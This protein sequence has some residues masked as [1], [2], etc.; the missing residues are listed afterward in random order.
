LKI[1]FASENSGF[2]FPLK[3]KRRH[4][5]EMFNPGNAASV[6]AGDLTSIAIDTLPAKVGG[7]T[8]PNLAIRLQ[9]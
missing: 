8:L 2:G 1:A 4:H 9:R 3:P 7:E 6:M 5:F